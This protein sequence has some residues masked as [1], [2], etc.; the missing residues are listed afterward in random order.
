MPRPE[1]RPVLTHVAILILLGYAV[2]FTLQWLM[3]LVNVNQSPITLSSHSELTKI[4][5]L[6]MQP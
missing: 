6:N 2:T 1:Y 4:E 5:F 3:R